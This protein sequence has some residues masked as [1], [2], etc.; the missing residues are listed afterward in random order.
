MFTRFWALNYMTLCFVLVDLILA[1]VK[2]MRKYRLSDS[3]II[4][5]KIYLLKIF[6]KINTE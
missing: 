1:V 4:F 6:K 3:I 2:C 5:K